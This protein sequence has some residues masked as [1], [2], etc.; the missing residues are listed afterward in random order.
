[1][2]EGEGPDGD[3]S[4]QE[5]ESPMLAH[6]ELSA[7]IGMSMRDGGREGVGRQGRRQIVNALQS[8]K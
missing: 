8:G 6:E 2:I 7:A 5:L 3:T 1:M 4:R